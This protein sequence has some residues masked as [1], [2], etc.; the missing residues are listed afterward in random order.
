MDFG[1]T[2]DP[3]QLEQIRFR[4]PDPDSTEERAQ[5]ERLSRASSRA[6]SRAGGT[7][8]IRVGAPIWNHAP[9]VGTFYPPEAASSDYLKEYSA[10]LGAVEMNSTF[11][12]IPA[13]ETF[14]KW[15]AS[16]SEGFRF[17]PKFPKSVSHSLNPEH[18]DLKIFSERVSLLE[19]RLGV[20]FLQFPSHVGPEQKTRLQALF[21][22]LPRELKTM[23]EFRN[24]AFFRD[25][26]LKPEWVDDL[27]RFYLGTVSVDTPLERDVAHTSLSSTRVLVRFLG[28]NLHESNAIRFQQWAE[29]IALWAKHGIREVYFMIHEPDNTY[30]PLSVKAFIETLNPLLPAPVKMPVFHDLFG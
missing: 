11:Y 30:T 1:Q 22:K 5:L 14:Q 19:D 25:Q 24:P 27:A 6:P 21:A 7:C 26:R 4:L 13:A 28:A 12:A 8:Q 3:A 23:V 17:C 16:V 2:L 29:R 20:C 15:R 10:Q 18:P 9:W